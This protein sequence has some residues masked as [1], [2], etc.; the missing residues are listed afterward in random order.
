MLIDKT[1]L[2]PGAKGK[3]LDFVLIELRDPDKRGNDFMIVESITKEEREKGIRGTILGNARTVGR[4]SPGGNTARTGDDS[5]RR[6]SET[7][8]EDSV[9]F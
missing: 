4:S 9:P 6:K 5:G 7:Q 2:F 1:R 8:V 3:Y